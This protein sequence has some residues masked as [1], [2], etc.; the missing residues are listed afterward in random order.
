MVNRANRSQNTSTQKYKDAKITIEKC[1]KMLID[2]NRQLRE[3][4]QSSKPSRQ[5][6]SRRKQN[7]LMPNRQGAGTQVCTNIHNGFATIFQ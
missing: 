4:E 3:I 6:P 1:K 5:K 7:T 2:T